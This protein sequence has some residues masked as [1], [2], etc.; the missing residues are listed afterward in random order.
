MKPMLADVN[1]ADDDGRAVDSLFVIARD[2]V[3]LS[4]PLPTELVVGSWGVA[5]SLLP[6]ELV[7]GSWGV[8][9][10]LLPTEFVVGSWGGG[11]PAST[12]PRLPRCDRAGTCSV[13]HP[14]VLLGAAV[15]PRW[16]TCDRR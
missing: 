1:L 13:T 14:L 6:T 2:G 10:S 3:A 12:D 7:V 5:R 4:L 15:S 11:L 9:L 8:S 16:L